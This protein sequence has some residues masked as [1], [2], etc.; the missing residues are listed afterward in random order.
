MTGIVDI[1]DRTL[2]EFLAQRSERQR[3]D[4]LEWHAKRVMSRAEYER[5]KEA[6]E[7]DPMGCYV[8]QG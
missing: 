6:G 4:F 3:K 7:L 8:I 2:Q 5:L 1:Y